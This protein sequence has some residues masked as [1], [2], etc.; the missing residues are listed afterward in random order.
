MADPN[1]IIC[2]QCGQSYAVRPEQWA[3]YQGRTINCTKCGKPFV[4][5][6][7][8]GP[9]TPPSFV[10]VPG[11]LPQAAPSVIPPAGAAPTVPYGGYAYQAPTQ[12]NGL[13]VLSLIFG[14]ISFCVVPI[15][16]SVVAIV[17]GALGLSRTKDPRIGGKGMAIAGLVLGCVSLVGGLIIIP[18]QLSVLLPALNRARE[19]AN[20]VKC[21]SNMRQLGQ[22][23]LMYANAN[24]NHFPDKLADLVLADSSL[25]PGVFV[26]PDDNKTPPDG[27]SPQTMAA[28]IASGQHT[29]YIYVGNGLTSSEPADTILLYEPLGNHNKEG[30]NVLY[31]DGHVDWVP[32]STAQQ[33]MAEHA[34]GQ[35]P[36]KEPGSGGP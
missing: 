12:G 9:Q 6:G 34:S 20:R 31:S 25:S 32:K 14:I 35:H 22:A 7:A 33:I 8:G 16:G 30:M 24:G 5:G 18:L 11:A 29:S 36:L 17:T 19:Q 10:P 21:A 2:P 23:M 15:I 1:Q 13:A 28:G 26:C 3:Q 27:T 4:V